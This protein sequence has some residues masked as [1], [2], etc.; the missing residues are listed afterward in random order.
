M[1]HVE[2]TR[3]RLERA[4]QRLRASRRRRVPGGLR[5]LLRRARRPFG[6]D[7]G[8]PVFMNRTTPVD[9]IRGVPERI[10]A[11]NALDIELYEFARSSRTRS[12]DEWDLT[13]GVAT[14]ARTSTSPSRSARAS[15]QARPRCGAA[16]CDRRAARRRPGSGERAPARRSTT[17]PRPAETPT[18]RRSRPRSRS[19]TRRRAGEARARVRASRRHSRRARATGSRC[20]RRLRETHRLGASL[21]SCRRA[22]AGACTCSPRARAAPRDAR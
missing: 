1:T 7:L 20:E 2:F 3:D 9:V 14:R 4:E 8:L 6:W 15:Y 21:C 19:A 16:S 22:P 17:S 10:A 5:R 12:V 11:D 18:S 13:L